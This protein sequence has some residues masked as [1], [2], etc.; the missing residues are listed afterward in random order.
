MNMMVVSKAGLIF[1]TSIM[2]MLTIP[3]GCTVSSYFGGLPENV[4]AVQ[5]ILGAVFLVSATCCARNPRVC[6]TVTT[7][8]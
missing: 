1:S 8:S 7:V 5:I 3:V 2:S 6:A 4:S